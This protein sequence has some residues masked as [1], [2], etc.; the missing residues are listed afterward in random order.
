VDKCQ[1]SVPYEYIGHTVEIKY[2][3]KTI[4]VFFK[5]IRITSHLR[6]YNCSSP[7]I[8]PEHMPESHKRYLSWN[9]DTFLEWAE[10]IGK[11]TYAVTEILLNSFK[12]EEQS[13]K[14]CGSLMKLVDRYSLSRIE[15]ACDRALFYT[16]TPSIKMIQT[17]L[18]TGSDNLKSNE[19]KEK[20]Q[21][22]EQYGFTRGSKN[23]GGKEND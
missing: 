11:S 1:Y 5:N 17:I 8:L 19:K 14:S 4:E 20:S 7:I 23:Y 6:R 2:S 16:P 9:R 18:K 10:S 13:Y 12:V 3:S 22:S 21:I 15:D